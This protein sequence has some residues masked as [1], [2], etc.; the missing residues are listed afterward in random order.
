MSEI[1]ISYPNHLQDSGQN[2]AQQNPGVGQDLADV[3]VAAAEH[4]KDSVSERAF[5]R[6]ARQTSVDFHMS[7][8]GLNAA[9]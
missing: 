2:E 6:A 1:A 9:T 4:G 8:L 3:V 7:N 5:Q